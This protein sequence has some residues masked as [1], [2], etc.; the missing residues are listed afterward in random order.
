M[1]DEPLIR[2]ISDTARWVATH[3]A[4]ETERSDALFHDPFARKLA[5]ERGAQIAREFARTGEW[6][7]ALRTHLF[8]RAILA[9]VEQGCDTVVNLAAG[10]DARPYRLRL[11][12]S[13]RW[14]EVD[15][16][17]ILVEKEEMLGG[18]TPVCRL[19]RVGLDLADG[20]ARRE[21]LARLGS[22]AQSALIVTEGLLIYFAREDVLGLARDLAAHASIHR[23][24]L[25]L[26][27][28]GLLKMAQQ[29]W[30]QRLAQG[31]SSLQ[32][33]PPEGPAFFEPAGWKAVEVHSIFKAAARARRV[34]FPMR[35]LA[36]LP[37]SSGHQGGRP[38]GGVCLMGRVGSAGAAG[39]REGLDRSPLRGTSPGKPPAGTF[40][41]SDNLA[42]DRA[43]RL[44]G[45]QPGAG[46]LCFHH[47][48][49]S[50]GIHGP[51]DAAHSE[52]RVATAAALG[53]RSAGFLRRQS[54][55]RRSNGAATGSPRR[56][57]GGTSASCTCLRSVAKGVG[58]VHALHEAE[59]VAP[60]RSRG[61]DRA[62]R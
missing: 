61:R 28:P 31:S 22:S 12:P 14:V 36:L 20:A 40:A 17:D 23:W 62:G 57:D 49:A 32:F 44:C 27:S 16:P 46:A 2:N 19:Q 30:G 37:E 54:S 55:T 7:W 35:L 60:S 25:D 45:A 41:R 11:P 24:A 21:L 51:M 9:C 5:G 15:L 18:E 13:L 33:G 8:D 3:R 48:S 1:H 38:W 56:S 42:P 29:S 59:V 4:I 52:R 47:V 43:D 50:N 58:A 26:T 53:G 39:G 34:P 10:L 6:A